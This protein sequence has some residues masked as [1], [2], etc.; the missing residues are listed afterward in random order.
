MAR[1]ALRAPGR[2]RVLILVENSSAPSDRRVRQEARTL[3][4]A[5]YDVVVVSPCGEGVDRERFEEWEGIEIHRFPLR[6]SGGGASGYV[7]E[8]GTALWSF[9]GI[10]W[11]LGSRRRF[12]VIHACNPPDLLFIVAWPLKLFGSRFVF[13][14]HDLAPELYVSRFGRRG[15]FYRALRLC[16]RLSFLAADVVVTTNESYRQI[17]V[18]RGRTRPEDVFVVR[19][20]PDPDEFRPGRPDERLK[21]GRAHLIA[22][23][24]LM[25][26]QD[27]LDSAIRA[28]AHLRR[29]RDDWHAIFMGDGEKLDE[30]RRLARRLGI[31]DAVEFLG[32][33]G[34]DQILPV[35]STADVCIA[36]ES[37]SPLNDRSTMIKVLE[38]MAMARPVVAFDLTETRVSAGDSALY[39]PSGNEL[40]FAE[41][42]SELLDQPALRQRLGE[43]GRARVV[44]DL[45]WHRSREALL[46]AYAA[47]LA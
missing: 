7:R 2:G 6:V 46:R 40:A 33:V 42:I 20:G 45:G 28:L 12:A 35:L 30:T 36:P 32:R 17:A 18:G 3:R 23:L 43:R 4:D 16:E 9:A 11:R 5:G 31:G 47:A 15:T 19:N 24:G 39:A 25:G 13:D 8:Y 29:R 1:E 22:Y 26:P 41:Q 37:S 44:D 10:I 14:H 27:G 38:Y 34:D 21:R